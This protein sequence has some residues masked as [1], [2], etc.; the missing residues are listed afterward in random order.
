[1]PEASDVYSDEN[2]STNNVATPAG[3]YIFCKGWPPGI[4]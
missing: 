4:R 3:S 2:I 1:M